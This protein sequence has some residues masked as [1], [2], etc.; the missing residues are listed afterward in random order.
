MERERKC[1]ILLS[2]TFLSEYHEKLK[3]LNKKGEEIEV[4]YKR[5]LVSAMT[6]GQC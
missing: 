4:L 6:E 1:N 5:L 2:Q 3:T